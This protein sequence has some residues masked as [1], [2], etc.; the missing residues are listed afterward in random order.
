MA[1]GGQLDRVGQPGQVLVQ[2]ADDD[3]IGSGARQ[4]RAL[5][6]RQEPGVEQ[7]HGRARFRGA[8]G[9]LL[10]ADGL[11]RDALLAQKPGERLRSV[12]L[13]IVDRERRLGVLRLGQ[14]P[15]DRDDQE[16]PHRQDEGTPPPQPDGQGDAGDLVASRG[17][18]RPCAAGG[19]GDSHNGPPRPWTGTSARA[20]S[21][22]GCV[23]W[24]ASARSRIQ[25]SC[26][27]VG[28]I[29]P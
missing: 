18:A 26:S 4:L 20:G 12:V 27:K 9:R 11:D 24:I 16:K 8:H 23:R 1:R 19:R 3:D 6:L 15:H 22:A 10:G 5:V 25:T 28:S 29:S 21:T 2:G 17:G 13:G 14:G 7:G